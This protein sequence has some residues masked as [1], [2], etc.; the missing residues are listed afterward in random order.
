MFTLQIVASLSLAWCLWE[1]RHDAMGSAFFSLRARA[2][3][4]LAGGLIAAAEIQRRSDGVL[5][6]SWLET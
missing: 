5:S 4:P 3:E 6:A 2:W 1:S